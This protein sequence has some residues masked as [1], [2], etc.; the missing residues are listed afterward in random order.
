M[1]FLILRNAR[2]YQSKNPNYCLGLSYW[3]SHVYKLIFLYYRI[4]EAF[5]FAYSVTTS[6]ES[7]FIATH[8]TIKEFN[9]DNVIYL[10][11]RSTPRAENEMTK[12]EYVLAILRAIEWVHFTYCLK[13]IFF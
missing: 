2:P 8:D 3:Q 6:A 12:K 5:S 13:Y 10:E 1:T 9:D 7:I 4:F 11:L